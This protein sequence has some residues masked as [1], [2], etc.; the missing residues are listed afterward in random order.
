MRV[1]ARPEERSDGAAEDAAVEEFAARVFERSLAGLEALSIYVGD[2]LGLYRALVAGPLTLEEF[3]DA[4][5]MH[6]RYAREWLEQQAVA[7]ILTVDGATPARFSLPHAHAQVLTD[8]ASLAYSAP[9]AR[10]VVAAAAQ[11]PALL[12]AYRAGGGVPWS[13]FGEDAREG[14]GEI[15]RPWFEHALTDALAAVPDLQAALA[16]PGARIA[17]VG[18]G[19]G[20]STIALAR[21]HPLAVVTGY[22]IDAPSVDAARLHAVGVPNVS[23]HL[24][25]G[26][27]VHEA[28]TADLDLAFIFEALHDMPHPVEVLD[29]LRRSLAPGGSLIVMDEAV[30]AEFAADGDEVERIMYAYSLFICLPDGMSVPDSAATGTVMRPAVLDGYARRAGFAGAK[31]LPIEGFSAFRFYRLRV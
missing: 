9:L 11:L 15:N 8:P 6:P 12:E 3:T 28:H 20:W 2:R 21:A 18:C 23:F 29:S 22:D 26:A 14:Q 30:A 10:F 7:G 17:D 19:V 31:V 27:E 25:S 13:Q 5:G 1:S 24:R 4:T 16:R